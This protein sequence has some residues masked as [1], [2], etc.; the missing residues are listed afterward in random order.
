MTARQVAG[1]FWAALIRFDAEYGWSR[2]SHITLSMM[3]A[4]FPFTIFALSLSQ[5]F[6]TLDIVG[7]IYGT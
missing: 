6:S 2:S 3:L 7:F 5:D 1:A 4:L